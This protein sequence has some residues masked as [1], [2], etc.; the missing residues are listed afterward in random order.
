MSTE[1]LADEIGEYGNR[2]TQH[3]N[4]PNDGLM[5][6]CENELRRLAARVAELEAV[7]EPIA[8]MAESGEVTKDAMQADRW[9][10]HGG[11]VVPLYTR[12]AAPLGY[13]EIHKQVNEADSAEYLS[14]FY[15]GAR[16]A[17]RHH[18]ITG[19]ST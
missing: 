13:D 4:N 5:Y 12:P 15:N 7:G 18:G 8:W 1:E 6:A 9:V 11:K 17:E 2:L 10:R 3:T 16:F 14:G 19:S